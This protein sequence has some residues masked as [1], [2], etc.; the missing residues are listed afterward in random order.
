MT[1]F[2]ILKDNEV[3]DVGFVFLKWNK[4]YQKLFVC[5][6]DDGQ[7][8]QSYDEK[9][10]YYAS[11]MKPHPE[12]AGLYPASEVVEITQGEYEDIKLLLSEGETVSQELVEPEPALESPEL[13]Q[14]EAVE[15]P[16]SIA[17]MRE[18]IAK[19]QE[20]INVLMQRLTQM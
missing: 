9:N 14:E 1:F 3:I 16:L 5:D 12:E 18:I 19:Q 20:Q 2:K 4:K 8:I 7:F 15:K 10:V 13:H 17:E 6:V 11:W